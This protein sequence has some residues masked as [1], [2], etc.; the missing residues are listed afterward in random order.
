MYL[1]ALA[2]HAPCCRTPVCTCHAIIA[3]QPWRVFSDAAFGGN[4]KG[5]LR[6]EPSAETKGM[7]GTQNIS[8]ITQVLPLSIL[9]NISDITT[10]FGGING[11]RCMI[12]GLLYLDSYVPVSVTTPTQN[13]P[14][15]MQAPS[16][17]PLRVP[18]ARLSMRGHSWCARAT[19]ASTVWCVACVWHGICDLCVTFGVV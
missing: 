9:P 12:T 8:A 15:F 1:F 17:P 2:P 11:T 3:L 14:A 10:S 13:E 5:V 7:L 16:L 4:S 6:H 18:T 19:W